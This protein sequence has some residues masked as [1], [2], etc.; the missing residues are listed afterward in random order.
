MTNF[1]Q[2]Y[3]NGTFQF[4][5]VR[6]RDGA[7]YKMGFEIL[8]NSAG[9]F[10]REKLA[11]DDGRPVYVHPA[12]DRA[13]GEIINPFDGKPE[14]FPIV[15]GYGTLLIMTPEG[16]DFEIRIAHMSLPSFAV[17]RALSLGEIVPAN[18]PLGKAGSMGVGTGPH[19]HTEI[20]SIGK[21]SEICDAILAGKGYGLEN[22]IDQS[23]ERMTREEKAFFRAYTG[24]RDLI[25][26]NQHKCV[27]NDGFRSRGRVTYYSSR[28]LFGM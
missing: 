28:S 21:T 20:V 15:P 24:P 11:F 6:Y 12:I 2:K 25:L 26:F 1:L 3:D 5:D 13:A 8:V 10:T 27:R 18:V 22:T 7:E 17:R 16:A 23:E 9:D 14:W 19:T 4:F